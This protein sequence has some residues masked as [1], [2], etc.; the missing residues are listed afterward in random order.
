MMAVTTIMATGD[1][2]DYGDCATGDRTTGYYDN[3][4][5]GDW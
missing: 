3:V 5:N 4:D 2:D 1:D